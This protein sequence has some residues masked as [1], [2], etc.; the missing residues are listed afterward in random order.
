MVRGAIELARARGVE[1]ATGQMVVEPLTL[2]NYRDLPLIGDGRPD[3]ERVS[4]LI[5]TSLVVFGQK[6]KSMPCPVTTFFGLPSY[7]GMLWLVAQNIR[8]P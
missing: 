8:L 1:L 2:A 3:S 6:A 4:F 7:C 5:K